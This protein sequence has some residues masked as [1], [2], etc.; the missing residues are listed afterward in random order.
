MPQ[1]W[2]LTEPFFTYSTPPQ[3]GSYAAAKATTTIPPVT[4]QTLQDL[5][6][7]TLDKTLAPGT[8]QGAVN[9]GPMGNATYSV[10]IEV[11][12]G[13]GNMVPNL[14]INYTGSGNGILGHGWSLGGLS[15]ISRANSSLYF[16]GYTQEFTDAVDFDD[17][18][19]LALDGSRLQV[20]ESNGANKIY[21]TFLE[22]YADVQ[23]FGLVQ[24]TVNSHDN[25]EVRTKD[26]KILNF[27]TTNLSAKSRIV[28]SAKNNHEV[29]SWLISQQKDQNGNVIAYQYEDDATFNH[30]RL[31]R[32]TYGITDQGLNYTNPIEIEFEYA[33]RTDISQAFIAGDSYQEPYLLTAIVTKVN[34]AKVG[35]YELEYLR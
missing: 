32:I 29:L 4:Y 23:G 3:P 2:Y 26:N 25:F 10:P 5:S 1:N 20:Y 8:L 28:A 22:N 21:K 9:V 33:L 12:P 11:P 6:Q 27:G 19:R 34:G 30:T 31:Q 24:G 17:F 14:T 16:N 35:R 18:D 7:R 15:A 13:L